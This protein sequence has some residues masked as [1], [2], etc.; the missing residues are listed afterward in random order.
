MAKK[1]KRLYQSFQPQ[2]YILELVP[3]RHAKTFSGSV[4]ISG[5]KIDRPSN[6]IILHQVGLKILKAHLTFHDKKGDHEIIIDR[7]NLHK[8]Y[9]E[10][11]LH[12]SQTLFPGRYTISLDFKGKITR[13]MNGIYPCDFKLRGKDKQLIATQ[14]ESHHAREVFPCIDEPEAKATFD[15]KLTT[16]IGEEVISNTPIVSQ[17]KLVDD[18]KNQ[19]T[20]FETTPKMSTYLLAFVYGDIKYK[21]SKTKQGVKVRTYATPENVEITNFA[22]EVAVKVLDF[23]NDYF[24]IDYPLS[25]CDL[26][27]LPDFA[28]GAMENWGC[29]TFREQAMLVDPNHTS[30][31]SKQYVA[32]V[33][34]HEL[35]H[36]WFG[37]LVTMRWWN[38]LW[39]NEGFASWIEYLAIDNLFPEWKMWTQFVVD[40][41]QQAL[42]MDA[43]EHTHPIEVP[44]N[45]PDEIRTIF[46]AISYSKGASVI[47]MLHDYL[48]GDVFRDGLRYYLKKHSYGNTHTIDLWSAF[49]EVAHKPVKDFMHEWI[50]LPGFP[51][52]TANIETKSIKLKQERFFINPKHE[53]LPEERWPVPLLSNNAVPADL[54]NLKQDKH[55]TNNGKM[56]KL[57]FGQNGFYRT[58]YNASHLET[59]GSQIKKGHIAS[60]DRLGL[61]SDLFEASKAGEYDTVDALHFMENFR[62]ES[63][64][65]VW[66][67]IASIIGSIRLVVADEE[68]RDKMKPFIRKLTAK[69]YD[70]L[71]WQRK[72]S[73]SHF[74]QLLRPT[75]L[76]LAAS[77]DEPDVV[78]RCIE[79]FDKVKTSEQ[80]TP[81]LRNA[82]SSKR[83][84]RGI[85]ID[86]DLRGM[87]FGTAARYGND[88]TFKKLLKMHN[89]AN[90]SE[91]R[92]TISAALTGFKQPEFIDKALAVI[93]SNEVRIQDVVYWIAYSFLNR[94]ARTQSWNWMKHNWK[95]LE[96]NLG[97]DL[98]FYRM[99]IYAA[100]AFNDETYLNEYKEF[101]GSVMTPALNRSYKQGIEMIQW[102]SAWKDKS[103]KEL[104]IF[105]D[106]QTKNGK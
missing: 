51:L 97:S 102:Q 89:S 33:V 17:E 5:Q 91:E 65:A 10:V 28:S 75:I 96:S 57:N 64:F 1:V 99:P 50:T 23:Y 3:N 59:L 71:G 69:Q 9:D 22:L 85:D 72:S 29:I 73:D 31:G 49:E 58:I 47:H 80:V 56:L 25:K 21:E 104:K 101:F 44:V 92:V 7:I 37:N 76:G 12:T 42:K 67:T 16:P 46:D 100:K 88:K 95:W 74:D 45:H 41:Q 79:L 13:Q 105:F 70:R 18:S 11:R 66:D 14:F 53:N 6:R 8:K 24:G 2:H 19:K 35:A 93:I 83:L 20:T 77:A 34:A 98:S 63:D 26:I 90:L 94:H 48:G 55:P 32:L 27:A 82:P 15:L 43:L 30:L 61:L 54:L 40:E 78:N 4:I 60:I 68:L 62:D 36:Q 39:L 87:V 52:I 106:N 38:D 103:L 81:E 86:P 84:K